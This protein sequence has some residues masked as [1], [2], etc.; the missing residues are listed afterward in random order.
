MLRFFWKAT[1]DNA[2][3]AGTKCKIMRPVKFNETFDIY[4]FCSDRVKAI[5]KVPR[6]KRAEEEEERAAKKLK[7]MET[8]GKADPE[9]EKEKEDVE[10]KDAGADEEVSPRSLSREAKG[11]FTFNLALLDF[12]P[13]S[14]ST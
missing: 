2:D 4:K 9:A 3:H 5:L 8:A 10:M 1:P 7:G 13:R 12:A 14:A 11:V 6:D